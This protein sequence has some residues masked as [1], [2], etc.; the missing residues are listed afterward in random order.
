[1]KHILT[2]TVLVLATSCFGQEACQSDLDINAN[3]AVDI[4]DFLHVLGLFGDV[5]ADGDGVWDSQDSCTDV[6][7]CN[8]DASPTEPCQALDVV[9]VCGGACET[10]LDEDGI[11]DV[12]DCGQPFTYHGQTYETVQIGDRCWF[13]ENLKT[14]QLQDGSD[15]MLAQDWGDWSYQ[16]DIET[17]VYCHYQADTAHSEVFGLLYNGHV[18]IVQPSVCPLGWRVAENQDYIELLL[19]AGAEEVSFA[20]SNFG[21]YTL[22]VSENHPQPWNGTNDL[23]FSAI[24]SGVRRQVPGWY[25]NTWFWS[26]TSGAN[27]RVDDSPYVFWGGDSKK[28]GGSIRCA[29]DL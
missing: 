3:G 12:H 11:C 19:E 20:N 26:G 24:N 2:L 5:D 18:A 21:G 29:R 14:T 23:G 17:P 13:A 6:E 4:A 28:W 16:S 27:W 25:G 8:Y 22:K 9:G 1:M 10:D 15:I 7:A